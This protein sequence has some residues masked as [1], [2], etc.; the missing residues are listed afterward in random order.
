MMGFLNALY[1]D[2]L[3]N[4]QIYCETIHDNCHLTPA[5]LELNHHEDWCALNR[6]K[7][8]TDSYHGFAKV[9]C[10]FFITNLPNFLLPK[11][12]CMAHT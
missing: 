7:V 6:I 12:F 5:D 10:Q 4:C 3:Y 11:F 8:I 1:F 2:N 9:F